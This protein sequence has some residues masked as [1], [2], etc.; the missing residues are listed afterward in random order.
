MD[1][2][3]ETSRAWAGIGPLRQKKWC[4]IDLVG[5]ANCTMSLQG[6]AV[7]CAVMP[8]LGTDVS[9]YVPL[10]Q[11]RQ[12]GPERPSPSTALRA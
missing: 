12:I 1:K 9:E 7:G 10:Y 2:P 11:T 5:P 8:H 6:L 4:P 3:N